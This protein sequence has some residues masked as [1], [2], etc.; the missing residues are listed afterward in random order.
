MASRRV[1]TSARGALGGGLGAGA[2]ALQILGLAGA[3]GQGFDPGYG[4]AGGLAAGGLA[5]G[6]AAIGGQRGE[7]HVGAGGEAIDGGAGLGDGAG[8]L[9]AGGLPEGGFSRGGEIGGDAVSTRAPADPGLLVAGGGVA[10]GAFAIAVRGLGQ[11][12]GGGERALGQGDGGGREAGGLLSWVLAGA[13]HRAGSAGDEGRGQVRGSGGAARV[14]EGALAHLHLGSGALGVDREAA[15]LGVGA[16]GGGEDGARLVLGGGEGGFERGDTGLGGGALG[17]GD[18]EREPGLRGGELGHGGGGHGGGSLVLAH[19]GRVEPLGGGAL[20][21][22]GGGEGREGG[23]VRGSRLLAGAL[24]GAERAGLGLP[25][26]VER[27]EVLRP[28]HR[29]ARPPELFLRARKLRGARLGGLGEVGP[30][31]AW[32]RTSAARASASACA[33]RASLARAVGLGGTQL[34]HRALRAWA[35]CRPRRRRDR[36]PSRAAASRSARSSAAAA[37]SRA[38]QRRR[39]P[40]LVKEVARASASARAVTAARARAVAPRRLARPRPRR[41]RFA[42]GHLALG[43]LQPPH[44]AAHGHLPALEDVEERLAQVLGAEEARH[45]LA[46]LRRLGLEERVELSLRQHHGLLE[47]VHRDAD[48]LLRQVLVRLAP[49]EVDRLPRLAAALLDAERR[50]PGRAAQLPQ[51]PTAPSAPERFLLQR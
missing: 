20:L 14:R 1:W 46:A 24:G 10:G 9:L 27:G 31:P 40:P 25:L 28:D 36:S 43:L 33:A 6:V 37:R 15:L 51:P 17:R 11:A 30:R 22:L 16:L 50:V 7:L 47:V 34:L 8:D 4:G 42:H 39:A 3:T 21:A 48:D 12:P 38:S 32:R 5:E 45:E 13:A 35:A 41:L 49:A 26:L 19:P 29:Q 44:L 2:G 23:G 18:G